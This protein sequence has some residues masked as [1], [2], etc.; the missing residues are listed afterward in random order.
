[1]KLDDENKTIR[2]LADKLDDENKTIR[3]LADSLPGCYIENNGVFSAQ[4]TNCMNHFQKFGC[5]GN[6]SHTGQIKVCYGGDVILS[7]MLGLT[8]PNGKYFCNDCLVS[9][10]DTTKG[11][12]HSPIILPK[13]KEMTGNENK[14][15]PLH[16]LQ[17]S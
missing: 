4:C 9:L 8:G 16:D 2:K 12:P 7:A 10:Q 5:T 1:M 11:V 17:D 14:D 13:Y 6:S 15:F 3:K